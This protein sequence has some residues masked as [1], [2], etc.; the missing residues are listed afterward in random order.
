MKLRS[1]QQEISKQG[2]DKIRRYGMVYLAMEVR[3]GKTLTALNIA[4][5][6]SK[7]RPIFNV[8]FVTKK[9]AIKGIEQDCELIG[10]EVTVINYESVHK[11]N[12]YPLDVIILDEAH[13]LGQ[14]PKPSKRFKDIQ[15]LLTK[16]S[17]FACI[18]YLSGTPSPESYSQLY[19]QF[20]VSKQF[21]PFKKYKNFYQWANDFVMV[22]KKYL[23]YSQPINDYS[24]ANKSAIDQVLRNYFIT[25]TQ[26]EAGFINKVEEK[27]LTVQMADQTYK[28]CKRLKDDLVIQGKDH[29]IL[30]DTPVKLQSKLHQLFSGTI[31]FECGVRQVLDKSKAIFI[32]DY[33]KG[34]KIAIFYKFI[35]EF[36]LL[37]EIFPEHTGEPMDF[38]KSDKL[39]FLGQIQSVREGI[40][41]STGDCLVMYNIDFSAVSY[42]QGR[43]R[44]SEKNRTKENIVYWIFSKDGIEWKV[45][46]VVKSKKDYTLNYFKKDYEIGTKSTN[47][48]DQG[49]GDQRILCFETN[50]DK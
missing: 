38:N 5:T 3:T 23:G 16:D 44:L 39:T 19:H 46:G 8:L 6:L 25:Y 37:K 13:G 11:I 28:M 31:K 47:K 45:Y 15:M 12:L 2:L 42:W 41:L 24:E 14:Y 29:I 1:Y 27:I 7:D 43:D 18:I 49:I 4:K 10:L 22:K 9:K 48:S 20:S 33:F 30:A 35:A 32:R 26:D 21:N 36:E 50:A 17:R 40:N 34:K